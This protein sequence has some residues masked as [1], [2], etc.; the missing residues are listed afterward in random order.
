MKEK[1]KFIIQTIVL[2]AVAKLCMI[3][4]EITGESFSYGVIW[5]IIAELVLRTKITVSDIDEN[6]NETTKRIY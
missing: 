6:R 3:C 1:I 4:G 5:C 2:L